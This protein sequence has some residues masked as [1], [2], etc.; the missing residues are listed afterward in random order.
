[1]KGKAIDFSGHQRPEKQRENPKSLEIG[2]EP[3]NR[4]EINCLSILQGIYSSERDYLNRQDLAPWTF[5]V[6][7]GS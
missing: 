1:L 5:Q 3:E 6:A 2:F 7:R 4:K